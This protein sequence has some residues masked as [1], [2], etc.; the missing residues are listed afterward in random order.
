MLGWPCCSSEDGGG[1]FC[2]GVRL[3]TCREERYAPSAPKSSK[4]PQTFL[5]FLPKKQIR[6]RPFS[7]AFARLQQAKRLKLPAAISFSRLRQRPGKHAEAWP[8]LAEVEDWCTEGFDTNDLQEAK[9][10]L[11]ALQASAQLGG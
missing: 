1:R 6:R 10:L 3:P 2:D 8:L 11:E 4:R 9:V 7:L 5:K